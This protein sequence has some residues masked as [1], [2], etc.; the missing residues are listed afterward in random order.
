MIILVLPVGIL[1][2]PLVNISIYFWRK[3]GTVEE[4]LFKKVF[5]LMEK[6]VEKVYNLYERNT[7]TKK[8][9][10]PGSS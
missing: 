3:K 7:D 2:Y 6:W 9:T 1:F 5:E 10:S 8:I 4:G